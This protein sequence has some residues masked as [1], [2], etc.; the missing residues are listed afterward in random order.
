MR[1]AVSHLSSVGDASHDVAVLRAQLAR[2]ERLEDGWRR[3]LD[4]S[5]LGAWSLD[6]A[7]NEF[8]YCTGWRRMRGIPD[9]ELLDLD[10]DNWILDVHPDDRAQVLSS[11]AAQKS[12]SKAFSIIIQYRERHRDGRW[13]WIESRSSIIEKDA[14]GS[15]L[16]V[17]GTDADVSDRKAAEQALDNMSRMLSLAIEVAEVGLFEA[18]LDTGQVWR[19]RRLLDMY[20]LSRDTP[21]L[22]ET[23]T[24]LEERLHLDDSQGCWSSIN[25]GL[26][27]G[28]P[29]ENQFRI[30][31]PAGAVRHMRS[32]SVSV[33]GDDGKRT[34]LGVT[35]DVTED[36]EACS[37]LHASVAEAEARS[38]ALE[39]ARE[40]IRQLALHD[41]LTG[42]LNRR[43]LNEHFDL[44]EGGSCQFNALLHLDLDG[45]K[46]INDDFGHIAGD[47][48]LKV[49]AARIAA[50][51]AP[52]DALAR[53]GGDE[54]VILCRSK[55]DRSDIKA[56]ALSIVQSLKS[57]MSVEDTCRSVGVSIG[58]ALAG[59]ECGPAQLMREADSALY[60]AKASGKSCVR[61]CS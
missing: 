21:E 45:F 57:P 42:L 18:D 2:F 44:W 39:E 10:L 14:A 46:A 59:P 16:R 40:T 23:G 35:W 17:V 33:T 11:I 8:V 9:D 15:S 5:N 58:I 49:A 31:T 28:L 3:A 48:V 37:A 22:D 32:R 20:G 52:E 6:V 61:F 50:Q 38:R 24:L 51:L 27:S 41:E 34:L 55:Q 12:G 54:F 13:I 1:S 36:V 4:A 19:D 25:T 26:A 56:L 60:D 47:A 7:N 30:S 43:G 29:F 53:W